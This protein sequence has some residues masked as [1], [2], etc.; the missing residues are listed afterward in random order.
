MAAWSGLSP[1]RN[2]YQVQAFERLAMYYE[3]VEKNLAMA[4][5]CT[6]AALAIERTAELEKRASRLEARLSEPRFT[7][8]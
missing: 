5:E 1:E 2:P 7:K 4:L 8:H 3:R 6:N